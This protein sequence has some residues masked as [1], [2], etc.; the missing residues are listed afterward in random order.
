MTN[1]RWLGSLMVALSG[2]AFGTLAVFGRSALGA[3]LPVPQMLALRFLGGAAVMWALTASRKELTWP[4]RSTLLGLS[5]MG[6]LF[7]GEAW[8]YFE[9]SRRIPV[10]LTA[11]LL[12]LFPVIVVI[13]SWLVLR[14]P[15][16]RS[17]ALAL[18]LSSIGVGLAIGAP[19]ESLD[20]LG[21]ALGAGA[22][23]SYSGYIL[24]GARVQ[25]ELAPTLRSAVVMTVAGL[26]FTI[27]ALGTSLD[28]D[29]V[30]AAWPALLGVVI[31]GTVLPI[32]LLLFGMARIGASRASI[33]STLEPVTAAIGGVVILHEALSPWQWIGA[34]LV[35]VGVLVAAK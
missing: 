23:L 30:A 35:L 22:A 25:P 3:G 19:V 18:L 15:L 5:A 33:I 16:G 29:V 1:Q 17:G 24:L 2:I 9:S 8:L 32:P 34:A 21:V 31:V 14:R 26:L 13:V 28:L 12:Y 7:V 4:S 11:L 20:P 6:A 27:A 10:G